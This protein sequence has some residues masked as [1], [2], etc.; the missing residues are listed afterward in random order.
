MTIADAARDYA[1]R[2]WKP[3]PVNRKSKKPIGKGWQ[4]RP[5]NPNQFDGNA[6]NIAIQLGACSG[7]LTDVDLDSQ[8]AIG[9]APE[10]LPPTG[11]IFGHRSKPCSHQLY[12]SDLF[13]TE[14]LATLTYKDG[15]A[16][17]VE[18]R[19]GGADKGAAS[20]VPPSMHVSG[21]MVEWA[22]NGAPAA[23]AG[24]EL[25]RAVLKL[26]VACLLMPRY[27]GQGSRH[28]A[29][30]VLGGT[31]ARAG[32][33][34]EEIE[35]L[36]G[37]L[38]RNAGD[39]DVRDR[40]TTAASAV[41]AKS[42]GHDVPGLTRLAELWGKDAADTLATWFAWRELRSDTADGG[43]EDNVALELAA[44]NADRLRY[45]AK[46]N[47]WLRWTGTRWQLEDTLVAFDT[48]RR[49][50]RAA[51]D[52]KS[53]TVAGVVALA[54][55]DRR[56]AATV[57]QWDRGAMLLNTTTSTVDLSNGQER[58]PK[59]EDYLTKQAGTWLASPAMPHPLW[60]A[61]LDRVT[62]ADHELIGFLQRLA[63]YCL[64]ARI[65]EHA[66]VF[67]YGSGANGKSVFVSTIS[68]ILGDYAIT[69]PMEMFLATKNDRH[70][71]EIARLKGAR[72]VTAQ[73]TTKGRRWDETKL[74]NLTGGDRLTGHFM[75]QDFFDFDPTHKLVISGN[76]KPGL[77]S[78][79]EAIRRRLLLV[80]FTVEIPTAERD[81]DF[82]DKL[83]PE[84]PAILRWMVDGCLEWQ[85]DGLAVPHRVRQAS[86]DYF[87]GQDTLEQWIEDCLDV[88][89]PR[90]FTT[91]RV[92]FTSWKGWTEQRNMHVG[93]EMAFVASL[94]E[95]GFEQR[96]MEYGR[97]FKGLELKSPDAPGLV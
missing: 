64:T 84:H 9:L 95:R 57:E 53:R 18:L 14:K 83:T 80:P 46:S 42:N 29:A 39:D 41:D 62:D 21:E 10:F 94:I 30:L 89:D 31:L 81:P 35:H 92:L 88:G 47:Q 97:G 28:E 63:G 5:F 24:G 50:C 65:S 70:P 60:S 56:L 33:P 52:A 3:V 1:Q 27:P 13:K 96:R 15:G 79:N 8:L 6:Q 76:H 12:N 58:D 75:R 87:A 34:R 61:F 66:L 78:V 90:A 20:V 49:L 40:A 48:A 55:S 74:K 59:R 86:D 32:W 72:L 51:R 26:A 71:T 77:S 44:E 7:G 85:R 91:T 17:I 36:V 38:A 67:L 11:A 2:G 4:K 82:A 19:V 16:V 68:R 43:L 22:R 37:V 54:R 69:A 73:E 93:T 23:V 25:K 45:V